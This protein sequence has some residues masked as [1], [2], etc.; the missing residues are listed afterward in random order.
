[1]LVK[2]VLLLELAP[3]DGSKMLV[4]TLLE[5]ASIDVS[6]LWHGKGGKQGKS[7]DHLESSES[8]IRSTSSTWFGLSI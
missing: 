4:L 5:L 2:L 8:R 3:V 6:K 1:M 7:V